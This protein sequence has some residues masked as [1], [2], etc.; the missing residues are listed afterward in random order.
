MYLGEVDRIEVLKM[1][2]KADVG[3]LFYENTT[4]NTK[5]CAPIKVYEYLNFGLNIAS[6]KN[7]GLHDFSNCTIEY[8]EEN[9]DKLSFV[10][11]PS[12]K[13]FV[14]NDLTNPYLDTDYETILSLREVFK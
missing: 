4:V 9:D 1:I 10:E 7:L 2:N 13:S 6:T 11:N 3:I 8:I 12:F 14:K 5:L